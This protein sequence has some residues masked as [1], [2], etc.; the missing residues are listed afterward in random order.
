MEI[1]VTIVIMGVAF[2]AILGGMVTSITV[3][4]AHRD[5][6]TADTIARNAAESVKD[7]KLAYSPCATTDSYASAMPAGSTIT[8]VEYWDGAAPAPT[9]SYAV[10]FSTSC[11]PPSKTLDQGLQRITITA[12]SRTATETV[13]VLKRERSTP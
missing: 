12:S 11:P 8:K 10:T 3:S 13:Q 9:A 1:L 7:P 2:T 5:Q 6:A 4:A